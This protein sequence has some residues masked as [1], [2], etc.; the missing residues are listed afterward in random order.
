MNPFNNITDKNLHHAYLIVGDSVSSLDKLFSFLPNIG[1]VVSGNPDV[2]HTQYD[3]LTIDI[4]R[5][6]TEAVQKKDFGSNKKIFIIETNIITEEA[7][8]ALLKVFEEP[9]EGTHIFILMPQDIILPTLR[10]R[11][12]ILKQESLKNKKFES[13]L[14]KSIEERLALVKEITDGISESKSSN[15]SIVRSDEVGFREEKTKQDAITFLNQIELMLY[16]KGIKKESERLGLCQL[17]RLALYNR[18]A[19]IKMILE[20]LMLGL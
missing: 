11:M 14:E 5:E 15:G 17:T 18:G 2:T 1:V 19:P 6:I 10:S 9:T 4:A 3:T 13:I 8:N 12:Q 20:N 16:I 7:Q